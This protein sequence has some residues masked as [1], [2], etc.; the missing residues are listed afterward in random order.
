MSIEL[1]GLRKMC[2]D[3]ETH[4]WDLCSVTDLYKLGIRANPW[5]H[6]EL[7][8]AYSDFEKR[9]KGQPGAQIRNCMPWRDFTL[10]PGY[11]YVKIIILDVSLNL[12]GSFIMNCCKICNSS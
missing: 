6:L 3:Q 12:L 7:D 4:I 11:D 5:E 10:Y 9:T 2:R 1:N 8:N